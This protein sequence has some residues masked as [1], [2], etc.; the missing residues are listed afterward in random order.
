VLPGQGI[1]TILIGVSL[2]E[3][4]GKYRLERGIIHFGPVLKGINTL[5]RRYGRPPLEFDETE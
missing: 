1:L 4:P 3:F 5:R 2:M